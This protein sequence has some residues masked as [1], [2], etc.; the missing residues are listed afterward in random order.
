MPKIYIR[1]SGLL[2]TLLGIN[3]HSDLLVHPKLGASWEGFALE[4]VIAKFQ[5]DPEEC[6]FFG[7]S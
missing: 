5:A 6:C 3:S 4:Q 2:H 1:D 7:C